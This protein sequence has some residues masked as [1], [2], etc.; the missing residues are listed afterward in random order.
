MSTIVR[1]KH[2]INRLPHIYE[3]DDL[4]NFCNKYQHIWIYGRG[5]AQEWLLRFL[6]MIGGVSVE[7]YVVSFSPSKE[8]FCYR[9]MPVKLIDDVIDLEDTGVILALPDYYHGDIIPRFRA[10]GFYNYFSLTEHSRLGIAEQIAPRNKDEM[11]FEISLADH[12]NL[13]CQMCDHFSQLSEEWFVDLEQLKKD[14]RQM[15]E[16]FAHEIGAITL[17]GGEPTLHP[18]LLE[19]IQYT[20]GQFPHTELIV[21]TNGVLL[22]KL[23]NSSSGNLWEVL[24]EYDVHVTVTVYPVKLDYVAIE[25]KAKEYGIALKMSSDIHATEATKQTKISDKHTMDLNGT[26]PKSHCVHCLY[27]NKFNVLKDGRYY[28]CPVQAHI[29]IFNKRFDTNLQYMEGD[30]LDIYQVKD[31]HEFAEFGSRWVPFCRFC[32]QKNWGHASEW[33]TSNKS[34]EEYV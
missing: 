5:E 3:I 29:N 8:K 24:K 12:C 20:R 22:T 7:G 16:I 14:M 28:M 15:G 18:D 30:Y 19:I 21:L 31:W 33:K 10:R 9:E 27:F 26:V 1:N 6:D 32:D 23:E 11:T 2:W 34:I 13:S 25:E 4:V 17:L